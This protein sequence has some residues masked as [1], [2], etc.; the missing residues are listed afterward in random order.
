MLAEARSRFTAIGVRTTT[1]CVFPDLTPILVSE[2]RKITPPSA[3]V[4]SSYTRSRNSLVRSIASKVIRTNIASRGWFAASAAPARPRAISGLAG[5]ARLIGAS[6]CHVF[7]S[8][9][10]KGSEAR[11][12]GAKNRQPASA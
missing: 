10:E 6:F 9:Q 4:M 2:R 3:N 7:T 5:Y 1:N 11:S 12:S 8:D